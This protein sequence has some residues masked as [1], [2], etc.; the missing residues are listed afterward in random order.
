M[1]KRKQI[2]DIFKFTNPIKW[3]KN[4]VI[5]LVGLFYI[6]GQ[7]YELEYRT[8]E[9][10]ANL[11]QHRLDNR[12]DNSP[13]YQHSPSE[14]NKANN[15]LAKK[16]SQILDS[17]MNKYHKRIAF[18]SLFFL[19]LLILTNIDFR[20]REIKLRLRRYKRELAHKG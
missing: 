18:Q 9:I 20:K 19:A 12:L 8:K 14:I 7:V 13:F 10:K 17:S 15:Y 4:T 1:E 2:K 5:L 6:F 16:E 11:S 3:S